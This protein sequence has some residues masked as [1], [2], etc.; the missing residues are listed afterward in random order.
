MR[1]RVNRCLVVFA[2]FVLVAVANPADGQSVDPN[3]HAKAKAG[4]KTTL[5]KYAKV[6]QRLEETSE[7]RYDKAPGPT[8][9]F[10]FHPHTRRDRIV[11]L[12]TDIL[13]ERSKT[14][15]GEPKKQQFSLTCENGDYHFELGKTRQDSDYAFLGSALGK[16]KYPLADQE[17]GVHSSA[18]SYLRQALGAIEGDGKYILQAL[19]FDDAKGLLRIDY[20]QPLDDK[21]IDNQLY[22]D[23]SLA[24]RVVEHRVETP[25][26]VGT[27]HWTY[28]TTVGGLEFPT[29]MKDLITYKVAKAPPNMEIT[30]RVLSIQLTDKT[31]ADFR[32]TA[33]GF[34]EPAGVAPLPKP[35]PRYVWILAAAGACAALAVGFA[36]LRRR[37][38]ARRPAANSGGSS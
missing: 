7:F 21:R 13:Q 5:E 26:L 37:S 12:G 38:Q 6:S 23:P 1:T 8:G 4:I 30:G 14:E 11:R 22:V 28:G 35:T 34:P 15:D 20:S 2:V 29:G 3:W 9:T 25:S 18:F 24:W 32:L 27:Q 16:A 33:F 36:Y 17:S 19:R 10:P 31:P